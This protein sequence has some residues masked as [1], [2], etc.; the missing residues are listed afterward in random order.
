MKPTIDRT[1]IKFA[2]VSLEI[3][4]KAILNDITISASER[5]V[6]IVGRNGSGKSTFCRVLAGLDAPTTGEVTISDVNISRDRRSAL[7]KVGVLFQNPDHQIIFPT[8]QEEL[9]FGLKQMGKS[10]REVEL[11]VRSTLER[12]DKLHW[13]D[14]SIHDLSQGQKQLVCL[15]AIF[16]MAPQVVILDEPFSGL[17]IP[18]RRQLERY[19]QTLDCMVVHVSHNPDDLLCYDRVVWIDGGKIALDGRPDQVLESYVAAMTGLGEQDDI[20]K[21]AS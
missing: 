12:F 17:D 5:R 10:K 3:R 16:A 7:K 2:N 9:A 6:G 18:T 8:I 19:I 14:A 13:I 15:M 4:G 21:L 11:G 20:S 1:E